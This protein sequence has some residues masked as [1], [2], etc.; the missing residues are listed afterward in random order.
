MIDLENKAN[1]DFFEFVENYIADK[2][3]MNPR[4][5]RYTYY[6]LRVKLNLTEKGINRFLKCSKIILEE[7]NYNVFFTG[8][9]F[10]F[11]NA[12]RVVETNGASIRV[13]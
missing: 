4:L 1:K 10:K 12:D 6:E 5:V 9:M 2:M 3:T 7:L 13:A 11:E 8:A